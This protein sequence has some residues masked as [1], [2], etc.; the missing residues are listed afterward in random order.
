MASAERELRRLPVITGFFIAVL[1]LTPPLD[2]KFIALGPFA[3]P[4]ATLLF[5]VAFILN[6]VLTEVY[7]YARSRR[8]IWTGMACQVLAAVSFWLVG[9]F[10]SA[11]FWHNQEAYS[12]ILGVVPRIAV[13]SF[14]A[15]LTGEFAN[16]FVLSRMKY[17]QRGR[18]GVPQGWRFLA[19][20]LVGEALDS[21]VFML[22]A[23]GG[24]LPFRELLTTMFTI[25]WIKVAVE[26]LALPGSTRLANWLKRVE[27]FDQLDDPASTRYSPFKLGASGIG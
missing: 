16:S 26:V 19:S 13:A 11:P 20:T 17:S 2:S 18:I 8:I 23:F 14:A 12:T 10:P 4:G 7:G 22:G 1:L 15:Y 27:A 21:V 24:V 3:V 6:D 5:P 25:Y 9:V